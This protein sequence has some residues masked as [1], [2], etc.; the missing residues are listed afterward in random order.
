VI[1]NK[2]ANGTIQAFKF[3]NL[4]QSKNFLHFNSLMIV[5]IFNTKSLETIILIICAVSLKLLKAICVISVETEATSISE[6][7]TTALYNKK[8]S[9]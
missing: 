6:R 5:N 8:Y 2:D 9:I 1:I 4:K 7:I 3:L